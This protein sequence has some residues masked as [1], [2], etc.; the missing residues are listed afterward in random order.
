MRK[1]VLITENQLIELINSKVGKYY[2]GTNKPKLEWGSRTENSGYNMMGYGI[3]LTSSKLEAIFYAE[4]FEGG[5]KYL[6][7]I[8]PNSNNILEWEG[9][10]PEHI[11]NEINNIKDIYSLFYNNVNIDDLELTTITGDHYEWDYLD[12]NLP[13]WA[14]NR[15]GKE[16]YFL[17]KNNN[18][19]N[20]K[21]GLDE[22]DI[23][24]LIKKNEGVSDVIELDSEHFYGIGKNLTIRKSDI[25]TSV[26]LLYAYLTNK[27]NSSKKASE[28]LVSLGVDGLIGAIDTS[29]YADSDTKIIVILN[30]D[31]FKVVN[32]KHL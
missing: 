26:K 5:N 28:L 4:K 2:H 14:K 12:S 10:V 18:F 1:K 24:N 23:N 25:F 22:K 11:K 15:G 13:E 31:K 16:G 29:D 7:E 30:L 8:I 17:I 3:Y 19:N 6:F 32:I 21:F 27:F 9:P 20:I